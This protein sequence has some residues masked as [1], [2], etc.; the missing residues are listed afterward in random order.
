MLWY[1]DERTAAGDKRLRRT[2]NVE[3]KLD[4][5]I[6]CLDVINR[7]EHLEGLFAD[8]I[9]RYAELVEINYFENPRS[10]GWHWMTVYDRKATKEYA[11]KELMDMLDFPVDELTVS[12]IFNNTIDT[13][14]H[15]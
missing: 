10:P 4:E 8:V 11:I 6:I 9:E 12:L 1:L 7:K 15:I 5:R 2:A 13:Y 3:G 14:K